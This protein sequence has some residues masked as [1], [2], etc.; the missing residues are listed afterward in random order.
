MKNSFWTEEVVS[1]IKDNYLL[2]T[3]E[4]IGNIIGCDKRAISHKIKKLGL[5]KGSGF[6]RDGSDKYIVYQNYFNKWT[7]NSAYILGFICADG[8][9]TCQKRNRIVITLNSKDIEILNFIRN[10]ISPDCPIIRQKDKD[11]STIYIS[12]KTIVGTLL[13]LGIDNHKTGLSNIYSYIPVEFYKD[14]IRGFFDGDGCISYRRRIRGKYSSIDNYFSITGNDEKFLQET[15]KI[16]GLTSVTKCRTWYVLRTSNFHHIKQLYHYMY[17]DA[18]FFLKR[19]KD[20]FE[21]LF[22]EKTK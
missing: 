16:I 18:N 15:S 7:Q 22:L 6:Y 13:N 12:G 9:V 8:H 10:E 11:H 21:S 5:K 1:F 2:K 19:K 4:E 14:F 20:K 17:N 3:Y